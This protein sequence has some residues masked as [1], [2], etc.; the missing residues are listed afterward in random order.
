LLRGHRDTL[1]LVIGVLLERETIDGADLAA[2]IG[3]PEWADH[4]PAGAPA[5]VTMKWQGSE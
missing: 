1:D 3:T 5:A 4:E 2:I